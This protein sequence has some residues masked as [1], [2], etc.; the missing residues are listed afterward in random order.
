MKTFINFI[1]II[2]FILFKLFVNLNS[3]F[4]LF[5]FNIPSRANEAP[6]DPVLRP[7]IVSLKSPKSQGKPQKAEK[8]VLEFITEQAYE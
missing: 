3:L 4:S 8:A 7:K 2:L 6:M 1:F 5:L